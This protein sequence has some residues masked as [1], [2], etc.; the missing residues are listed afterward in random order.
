MSMF[1][2]LRLPAS[3][4]TMHLFSGVCA[5]FFMQLCM[6]ILKR[7]LTSIL[8]SLHEPHH[9]HYYRLLNMGKI[10]S[11]PHSYLA[12]ICHST[13][14]ATRRW[15]LPWAPR[16]ARPLYRHHNYQHISPGKSHVS[17]LL[18][19]HHNHPH[20][21]IKP[22]RTLK[23]QGGDVGRVIQGLDTG[24]KCASRLVEEAHG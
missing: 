24:P 9:L 19:H 10:H 18:N 22:R 2:V 3:L 17:V 11:Q 7:H 1:R 13:L 23:G 8:I 15:P 21:V 16:S 5:P 4:P 12:V 20:T 14:S 6:L